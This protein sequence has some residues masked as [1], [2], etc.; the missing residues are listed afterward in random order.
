MV[1]V[2]KFNSLQILPILTASSIPAFDVELEDHIPK[3]FET[4]SMKLMSV[5]YHSLWPIEWVA[6]SL[7]TGSLFR[8]LTP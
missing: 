2:P 5:G 1:V 4:L 8:R 3:A 6:T 7:I